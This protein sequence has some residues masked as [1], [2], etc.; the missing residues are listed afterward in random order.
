MQRVRQYT[1]QWNNRFVLCLQTPLQHT[2]IVVERKRLG[3]ILQANVAARLKQL[4]VDVRMRLQLQSFG[5]G[6][7][8]NDFDATVFLVGNAQ[9]QHAGQL[10]RLESTVAS[11]SC[12]QL[13]LDA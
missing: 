13:V 1:C 7:V 2:H 6:V 8:H 10:E 3:R 9:S 11:E 5:V 4:F 12:H